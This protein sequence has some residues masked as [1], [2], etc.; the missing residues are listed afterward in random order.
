MP[1]LPRTSQKYNLQQTYC[2]FGAKY[3]CARAAHPTLLLLSQGDL[4]D[5]HFRSTLS[6]N[7]NGICCAHKERHITML[8]NGWV[9]EQKQRMQGNRDLQCIGLFFMQ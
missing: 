5:C 9:H 1:L 8:L 3:E 2:T 4:R 7:V 6:R